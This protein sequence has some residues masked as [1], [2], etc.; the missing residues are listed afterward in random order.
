MK[1]LML[2]N[3]ELK[4]EN[5]NQFKL[6]CEKEILLDSIPGFISKCRNVEEAMKDV[7]SMKIQLLAFKNQLPEFLTK[8]KK[9]FVLK[10][11][12]F[13]RIKFRVKLLMFFFLSFQNDP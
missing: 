7:L 1:D 5:V 6:L 3:S 12:D 8:L 2:K 10:V 4:N 11:Q 13:E 9:E